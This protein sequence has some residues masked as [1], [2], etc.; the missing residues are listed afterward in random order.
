MVRGGV[1]EKVKSSGFALLPFFVFIFIYL[2]TGIA[3]HFMGDSMAFYRM[4]SVAAMFFS[5]V[6][7][8]FMGKEKLDDK[9]KTFAK[10]ASNHEVFTMLMI[11]ILAGAFA[12]VATAMG[13]KDST[14][15]LGLSLIPPSM[16][17]VGL[18]IVAA[19]FGTA[20]GSSM[21][22]IYALVPVA[23]GIAE[24]S[25]VSALLSVSSVVC[26]AMLGD[27]L[28]LIS[29]TTIVATRSQGVA[30]KDKFKINFFIALPAAILTMTIFFILGQ[31]K[32]AVH[33]E[34]APFDIVKCIPYFTVLILSILGL[35]VFFTLTFSTFVAGIIGLIKGSLTFENFAKSLYSG[36][37]GM[38][39]VFFLTLFCAGMSEIVAKNG[40]FV[41]IIDKLKHIIKGE[42]S[43][44][45]SI[46]ILVSS[47]VFATAN[48]TVAIVISGGTAKKISTKHNIDPR[49]TA[50]ILDIFSCVFKGILPYGAQLVVAANMASSSTTKG[51]IFSSIDLVPNMFYCWFLSISCLLFIFFPFFRKVLKKG[52]LSFEKT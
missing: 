22:T 47:C 42:R 27:N 18:F 4:P 1:V 28:S 9:F 34:A 16:V 20:T 11:Y 38:N 31:T 37:C 45:I 49:I 2:G 26:G 30:M 6:V 12:S 40:G 39:E 25:G 15:S 19:F 7:A 43:A 17:V 8:F 36:I 50:S 13:A 44:M 51:Q 29:D 23:V 41:W 21:G 48:N 33:L 24:K 14:V 35:N 32:N 3:Y 46:A 5:V 10:G 52:S